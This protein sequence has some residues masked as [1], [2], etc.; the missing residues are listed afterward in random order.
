MDKFPYVQGVQHLNPVL[1]AEECGNLIPPF[2]DGTW[3]LHANAKVLSSYELE[4]NPTGQY[5]SSSISIPVV[6]GQTYTL[7]VQKL[8]MR[9]SYIEEL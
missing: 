3:G 7:T 2:T 8:V 6:I 4:L 5:N 9:F 1:V